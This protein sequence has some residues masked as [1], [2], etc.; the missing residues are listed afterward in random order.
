MRRTLPFAIERLPCN[1]VTGA[2]PYRRSIFKSA[3][4][5]TLKRHGGAV[6]AAVGGAV[7]DACLPIAA[8]RLHAAAHH[9]EWIDQIDLVSPSLQSPRRRGLRCGSRDRRVGRPRGGPAVHRWRPAG[10]GHKCGD[11]PSPGPGSAGSRSC[12]ASQG[13]GRIHRQRAIWTAQDTS[14]SARHPADN[15]SEAGLRS[16]QFRKLFMQ[17]PVSGITTPEPYMEPRLCVRQTALPSRST[18]ENEVVCSRNALTSGS[19]PAP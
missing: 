18:A 13:R 8:D 16:P 9:G 17:M 4:G 14:R 12:P 5:R 11:A 10:P 2:G 6:A 15:L 19:G 3:G 1:A 7:Q